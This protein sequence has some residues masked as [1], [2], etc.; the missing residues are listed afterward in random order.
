[1]ADDSTNPSSSPDPSASPGGRPP[2]DPRGTV[3]P[4]PPPPGYFPMYPPPQ[5]QGKTRGVLSR[6]VGGLVASVLLLSIVLNFYLGSMVVAITSGPTEATYRDGDAKHRIVIL[7][8]EGAIDAAMADFV[9]KSLDV[10]AKKPPAAIVLRVESGGG[11]VVAS[12]QIWHALEQYKTEHPSVPI[13]ASFGGVAASGGYYVAAPAQHIFCEQTG[14]TGSIGVMAQVP[15]MGG[16]MDKLGVQWETFAARGSPRKT[17]AN[18]VFRPWDDQDRAAVEPFL[19]HAYDRFTQVVRQGR[20]NLTV[21]QF[22]AATTGDA[23]TAAKAKDIGL[24]DDIGYLDDAL[25]HAQQLVSPPKPSKVTM[26]RRPQ[27]FGLGSLLGSR[28]VDLTSLKAEQ[29]SSLV[30]ELATPRLA[31]VMQWR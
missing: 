30:T 6:M 14:V 10:L 26:I 9:R 5:S 3:L 8:V 18:D 28:Q 20:P 12:D 17:I 22:A 27:S 15:T 31:Y 23:F 2:L 24:I 4:P 19:D 11:S 25:A 13:I 16:L 7:P 29:I 21:D 1:M